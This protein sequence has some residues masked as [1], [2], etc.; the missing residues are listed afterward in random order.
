MGDTI[1][2]V[3]KKDRTERFSLSFLILNLNF[4]LP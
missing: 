2:K 4:G 3:L 1:K